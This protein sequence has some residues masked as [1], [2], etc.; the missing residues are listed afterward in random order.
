[1]INPEAEIYVG[2]EDGVPGEVQ[3][4]R[5]GGDVGVHFRVNGDIV[6]SAF[7]SPFELGILVGQLTADEV[8]A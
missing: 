5:P 8:T 6:A 1:M 3:V 4:E 2:D 7:F